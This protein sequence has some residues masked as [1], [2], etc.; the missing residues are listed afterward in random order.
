ML[1]DSPFSPFLNT[2][3]AP[4]A[5]EIGQINDL[6]IDPVEK[7]RKLDEEISQL[8][9]QRNRLQAFI[10]NHRALISPFRRLPADVWSEI[11]IQ[12]L[13]SPEFPVRSIA[14]APLLLTA[15]CR[16]WR[17][18]AL[19]TPRI[20]N[21]LHVNIPDRH[22]KVDLER[23]VAIMRA[24]LD[25]VKLWLQRSGSIPLRL[26]I[27]VGVPSPDHDWDWGSPVHDE[28]VYHAEEL[29][30]VLLQHSRRWETLSLNRVSRQVLQMLAGGD[31][32]QLNKLMVVSP[33]LHF[34][35]SD[36]GSQSNDFF[37]SVTDTLEKWRVRALHTE[38]IPEH[39]LVSRAP[40]WARLTELR[41][42]SP[43]ND[44]PCLF[45]SKITELCPLLVQCTLKFSH[46][47]HD[48]TSGPAPEPFSGQPR[49]WSNLQKL[50]LSFLG[51]SP[52][53]HG[54]LLLDD[55]SNTFGVFTAP[56][57]TDLGLSL[58]NW[59][60]SSVAL[61]KRIPETPFH[62]FLLRSGSG[63]TLT[64]LAVDLP[65]REDVLI[66]SLQV[67]T[68]LTELKIGRGG[69]ADVESWGG[70]SSVG[71]RDR[72]PLINERLLQ[73]LTPAPHN[74]I[75]CPNLKD[76]DL[77]TPSSHHVYALV[78][79]ASSRANGTSRTARLES[80]KVSF[81]EQLKWVV[82]LLTCQ[83]VQS[84]L[85]EV[86]SKGVRVVWEWSAPQNRRIDGPRDGMIC[87]TD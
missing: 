13:P 62:R 78:R 48:P 67:L 44:L 23:Y 64:R 61:L 33:H 31:A 51:Y 34:W 5:R 29:A 25:G 69:G 86:R 6:L 16:P 80:F 66:D 41:V 53:R 40:H 70:S 43:I 49:K 32:P 73:A 11:S 27:S 17:E 59:D 38:R 74:S 55:I 4:S 18:I 3:Y 45:I 76:L 65:L 63:T 71:S 20:W 85:E 56:S 15:I 14:E 79:L 58:Y 42:I 81:G 36:P 50:A 24:R 12:C 8:Q 60:Y 68:S 75:I 26:S 52:G 84:A 19:K 7:L 28:E 1:L 54:S 46:Y 2:N 83:H 21:S 35:G 82:E 22:L 77:S 87:V 57:L 39:V 37:T 10:D 9:A 47:R 72:D 30:V